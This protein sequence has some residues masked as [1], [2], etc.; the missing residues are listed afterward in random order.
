[1]IGFFSDNNHAGL[2]RKVFDNVLGNNNQIITRSLSYFTQTF[3]PH[4]SVFPHFD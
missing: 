2:D 4:F 1:M 3:W